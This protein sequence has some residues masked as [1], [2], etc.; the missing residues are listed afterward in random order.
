MKLYEIL[1]KEKDFIL[2]KN[3]NY[4]D[5]AEFNA[6]SV[7]LQKE[8]LESF[9]QEV[10]TKSDKQIIELGS[11]LKELQEQITLAQ[12]NRV[13]IKENKLKPILIVLALLPFKLIAK[14][15]LMIVQ[16]IL[17]MIIFVVSLIGNIISTISFWIAGLFV[18]GGILLLFNQP[19]D[20]PLLGFVVLIGGFLIVS[21][22]PTFLTELLMSLMQNIIIL[23]SRISII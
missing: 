9:V 6:L 8:L 5:R 7:E 22:I 2:V 18:V 23:N 1:D 13:N 19:T 17:F 14:A 20:F 16:L 21:V 15:L 4:I 3:D 10:Y 12:A 11:S